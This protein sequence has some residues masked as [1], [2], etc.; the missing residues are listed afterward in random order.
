MDRSKLSSGE[1]P[2]SLPKARLR[3]ELVQYA[4]DG[5]RAGRRAG[6]LQK[7]RGEKSQEEA[8]VEVAAYQHPGV[9]LLSRGR[10]TRRSCIEKREGGSR[11][12][13]VAGVEGGPWQLPSATAT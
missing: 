4:A 7:G 13:V 3:H 5:E 10:L 8:T 11:T 9:G 6:A 2:S 1:L 12:V